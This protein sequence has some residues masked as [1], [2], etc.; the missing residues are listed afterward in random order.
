[1]LTWKTRSGVSQYCR[2]TITTNHHHQQQQQ[3]NNNY[4]KTR[5]STER[6][7]SEVKQQQRQ[8]TEATYPRTNRQ[9][10]GMVHRQFQHWQNTTH[11]TP[12]FR[13]QT[14]L[15]PLRNTVSS[16]TARMELW[17]LYTL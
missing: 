12:S 15:L 6:N 8:Y 11:K 2:N 16:T 17:T 9:S 4:N 5:K 14:V 3:H 1:M 10:G 7:S 13:F